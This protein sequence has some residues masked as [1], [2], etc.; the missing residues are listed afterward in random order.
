MKTTMFAILAIAMILPFSGMNYAEAKEQTKTDNLSSQIDK[1]IDRFIKSTGK[2]TD[3]PEKLEKLNK[4]LDDKKQQLISKFGTALE[5]QLGSEIERFQNLSSEQ[6]HEIVSLVISEKFK[7]PLQEKFISD[8]LSTE[9][10]NPIG[11][12][13]LPYAYANCSTQPDVTK[14]KQLDVDITVLATINSRMAKSFY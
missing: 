1:E 2:I 3:D 5:E 9:D 6:K 4:E 7:T 12:S 13:I 10:F 8:M 11:F 14:F